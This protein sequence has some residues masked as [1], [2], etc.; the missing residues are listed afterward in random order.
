VGADV[1][2]RLLRLPAA[3]LGELGAR[4]A[5]SNVEDELLHRRRMLS[6]VEERLAGLGPS[7]PGDL[8]S[9]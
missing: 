6:E 4:Q 3:Y 8:R 9:A 1:L 7:R 2:E 5:A